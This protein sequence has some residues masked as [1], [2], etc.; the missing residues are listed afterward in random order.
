MNY[1]QLNTEF[2]FDLFFEL[3]HDLPKHRM[4]YE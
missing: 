1:K 4:K 2:I 3:L